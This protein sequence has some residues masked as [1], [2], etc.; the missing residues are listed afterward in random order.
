M[1]AV[2]P[3]LALSLAAPMAHADDDSNFQGPVSAADNWN[4]STLPSPVPE[5][6]GQ[7]VAKVPVLGSYV[8]SQKNNAA[9]GNVLDHARP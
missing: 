4:F 8:G 6:L 3:A 5:I 1:I 2:L 9:N 7:E